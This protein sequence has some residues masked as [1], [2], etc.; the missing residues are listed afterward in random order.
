MGS[1]F[2]KELYGRPKKSTNKLEETFYKLEMSE[3]TNHFV[4][5]RVRFTCLVWVTNTLE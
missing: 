4:C 1:M 5:L 3:K 2:V